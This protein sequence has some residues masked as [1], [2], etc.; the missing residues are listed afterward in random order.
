MQD[1]LTLGAVLLLFGGAFVWFQRRGALERDVC[2]TL[3]QQHGFR[4]I[5]DPVLLERYAHYN[6]VER[7]EGNLHL[8]F[9]SRG[10]LHGV[11]ELRLKEARGP[12]FAVMAT[13]KGMLDGQLS[14]QPYLLYMEGMDKLHVG[15]ERFQDKL[16]VYAHQ[17]DEPRG[18]LP[19][20]LQ[21]AILKSPKGAGFVLTHQGL[22]DDVELSQVISRLE[23]F[24]QLGRLL[25][26]AQGRVR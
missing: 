22:R 17:G 18:F 19:G 5:T 4:A 7:D 11:L 12:R 2:K 16:H 26:R 23:S 8:A 21:E 25:L 3:C 14:L 6:A 20:P 24:V 10:A 1:W 13:R 9:Y 15:G